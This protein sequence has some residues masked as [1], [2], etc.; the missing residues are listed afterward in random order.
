MLAV[1]AKRVV[2]PLSRKRLPKNSIPSNGIAE[3]TKKQ[4][5]I[6]PK[7]GKIIFSVWLTVR[8]GFILMRRSFLVVSNRMIGG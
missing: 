1:L 5:R 6:R 7:I 3:G 8:A 2:T 4:V